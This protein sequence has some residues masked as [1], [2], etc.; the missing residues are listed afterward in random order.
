MTRSHHSMVA[1]TYPERALGTMCGTV[2]LLYAASIWFGSKGPLLIACL[3]SLV[4]IVR[5]IGFR[6]VPKGQ[7]V[8]MAKASITQLGPF[9]LFHSHYD[10][11]QD[12]GSHEF[13]FRGKYL[14]AGCH[15]LALGT[16]LSLILPFSHFLYDLNDTFFF[17]LIVFTPLCFLPTILRCFGWISLS[18]IARFLSYGVLPIGSWIILLQLDRWFHHTLVNLIAIGLICLAWYAG[19][20]YKLTR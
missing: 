7:C 20:R 6:I 4:L 14:C 13:C 5:S 17:T 9:S 3:A 19:G 8:P 11:R 15:G 18:A 10:Q 1:T 12:R 16:L 2:L